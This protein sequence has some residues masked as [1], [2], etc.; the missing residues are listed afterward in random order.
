MQHTR[1]MILKGMLGA[2]SAAISPWHAALAQNASLHM[3]KIPSTEE[4]LPLVGLGTWITFNVGRDQKL[5][6]ECA[7]VMAAFFKAGG[8]LIDSSPMYGSSQPT[9]GYGL[10]KLGY[11]PSL[12]SSEKVWQSSADAGLDQME[13]SRVD[14]GVPRFDLMQVHNLASWEKHLDQL[15][16]MKADGKLRYLG[17]TTSHGRRHD[18]LERIM[19]TQ[20]IDFVQFTYNVAD[21]KPEQR[22]LPIAQERGIGAIINRPFRRGQLI[23]HFRRHDLPKWV[24]ETGASSWA[25]FLLKFIISH[26]AINCAI[27]ATTRTDHVQENLAAATGVMPDQAMRERMIQYIR[28]L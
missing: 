26:P 6:D 12:F 16:A 4:K 25:Q 9:V 23:R 22:L 17:V 21:R 10:K 2:A 28:D 18:D 1:R 7:A 14:W 19:T 3:R 24:S 27:P 20:P 15:L 8:Q 11:P 13:Q 5:L